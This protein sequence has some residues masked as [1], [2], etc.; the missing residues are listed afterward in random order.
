[1][2]ATDG[3]LH[4]LIAALAAIGGWSAWSATSAAPAVCAS[5][6]WSHV[7][8]L[9]WED[10]RSEFAGLLQ[11][12]MER[13]K[14]IAPPSGHGV[15]RGCGFCGIGAVIGKESA[16]HAIWGD[17]YRL[18]LA[19][20]GGR[21]G[22]VLAHLCPVCRPSLLA[23]GNAVG[24]PA[25]WLSAIRFRGY[26]PRSSAGVVSL[27]GVAPWAV[28][29]QHAQPNERPWE[30]IDLAALDNELKFTMYVRK[31]EAAR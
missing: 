10:A 18:P 26:E 4:D 11:R 16:T 2:T 1:L 20:L 17:E 28:L 22:E 13:P 9:M 15:I 30:H 19:S 14:P 29:S 6:R 31:T 5:R 21:G 7:S 12:R 24:L 8:D 3:Y 23:S 25:A 27:S